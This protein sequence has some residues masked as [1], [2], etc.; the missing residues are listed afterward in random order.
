MSATWARRADLPWQLSRA[1]PQLQDRP[2]AVPSPASIFRP[3]RSEAV[4]SQMFLQTWAR[5]V[6]WQLQH[7]EPVPSHAICM[8]SCLLCQACGKSSYGITSP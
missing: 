5:R 4:C 3:V 1:S 7:L 2:S 6:Y 8:Y